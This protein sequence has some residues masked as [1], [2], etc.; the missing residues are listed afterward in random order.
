MNEI[1]CITPLNEI[2]SGIYDGQGTISTPQTKVTISSDPQVYHT[3]CWKNMG[4]PST[5]TGASEV[6]SDKGFFLD[7]S[8]QKAAPVA[9]L[10]RELPTDAGFYAFSRDKTVLKYAKTGGEQITLWLDS[11]EHVRRPWTLLEKKMNIYPPP[12]TA[13]HRALQPLREY[14]AALRITAFIRV[15]N[16]MMRDVEI[17]A[18]EVYRVLGWGWNEKAFQEALKME[19]DDRG[20]RVTSEIP[21]TIMYK[22]RPMGDGVNV[23]TDILVETRT[24]PTKQL[25]LELKA[26]A[27]TPASLLKAKQQ[28]LRYLQLKGYPSGMVVNFPE[29]AGQ[30]VKITKLL[31]DL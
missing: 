13:Q 25:L 8:Y 2:Y 9:P 29:R 19:L 28:C 30:R 20:Y 14:Y 10:A 11:P 26:D 31:S 3:Q 23:R 24:T 5:Y 22:G 12:T 7:A 18:K 15:Q 21:H 27:A 6:A 4:N 17:S 1:T 16:Q